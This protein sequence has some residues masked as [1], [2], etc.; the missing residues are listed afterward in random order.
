MRLSYPTRSKLWGLASLRFS[1]PGAIDSAMGLESSRL[2]LRVQVIAAGVR[3]TYLFGIAV[4]VWV[5]TTWHRP[6]RE[7]L[8]GL[9]VVAVLGAFLVSRLPDRKSV[10]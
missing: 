6:Y 7:Q 9:T 3:V 1:V 2:R 10:V 8:A 5:A 4:A